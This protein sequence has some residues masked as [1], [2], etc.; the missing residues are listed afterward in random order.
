MID[1]KDE[2]PFSPIY[3]TKIQKDLIKRTEAEEKVRKLELQVKRQ[4]DLID[5][6]KKEYETKL[7]K[8]GSIMS[9]FQKENS[10]GK[11]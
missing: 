8:Q 4:N 1:C 3:Q 9:H 10:S 5:T 2:C 6:L 11:Y 7:S